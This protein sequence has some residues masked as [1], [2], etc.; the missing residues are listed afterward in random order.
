MGKITTTNN[1]DEDY[2]PPSP[3][4]LEMPNIDDRHTGSRGFEKLPDI[5]SY[6]R[7]LND[8]IADIRDDLAWDLF[9]D[10][11]SAVGKIQCLERARNVLEEFLEFGEATPMTPDAEFVALSLPLACKA[12]GGH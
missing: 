7:W 5:G 4:I 9:T 3:I 2:D 8:Q 11:Q 1:A 12:I 10:R 6:S